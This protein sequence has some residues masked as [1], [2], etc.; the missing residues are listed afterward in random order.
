MSI[1]VRYRSF[2]PTHPHGVR[3]ALCRTSTGSAPVSTHAPARGATPLWSLRGSAETIVSTHAPARG[4]TLAICR[5]YQQNMFQPTHPH[6]VR[7]HGP[8]VAPPSREFQPT[9]PH[10]V[11]PHGGNASRNAVR[12]QPTH[13]HGVRHYVTKPATKQAEVSTHAPARGATIRGWDS[14]SIRAVSTHAPARGA[15]THYSVRMETG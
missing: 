8:Q 15:T 12:F 9:H 11:R 10:G 13:P 1:P 6:G 7:R 14:R 4:A 2:Q 3:R 5:E